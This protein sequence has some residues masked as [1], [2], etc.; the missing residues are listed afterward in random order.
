MEELSPRWLRPRW[1]E[2]AV[3]IWSSQW[4]HSL[5]SGTVTSLSG[6][7][8]PKVASSSS[9]VSVPGQVSWVMACVL[10]GLSVWVC[11]CIYGGGR[12]RFYCLS[13]LFNVCKTLYLYFISI[14]GQKGHDTVYLDMIIFAKGNTQSVIIENPTTN[15]IFI[16]MTF[17]GNWNMTHFKQEKRS[18]MSH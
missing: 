17:G 15:P 11:V 9:Q 2:R 5:L 13:L 16:P 1:L 3:P 18:R 10:V 6:A 14:S 12:V 4:G 7:G 8:P